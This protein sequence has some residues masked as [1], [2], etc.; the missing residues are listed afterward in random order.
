MPTASDDKESLMY[1][2]TLMGTVGKIM[3]NLC[4][5]SEVW[6]TPF[7]WSVYWC[8]GT[9]VCVQAQPLLQRCLELHE[10]HDDPDSS[11]TGQA[12]F[13]LA[14][15]YA[16]DER[17]RWERERPT[18]TTVLPLSS[19]PFCHFEC[20]VFFPQCGRELL[21]TEPGSVW[22][23]LRR[24]IRT[25]SQGKQSVLTMFARESVSFQRSDQCTSCLCG[26]CTKTAGAFMCAF[27]NSCKPV[28]RLLP[29]SRYIPAHVCVV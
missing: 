7:H 27:L 14:N 2:A 11:S 3:R 23:F 8:R 5:C 13:E 16:Q 28:V 1:V 15:L 24:R 12:M 25:S 21:Q 4:L 17:Y 9:C 18:R 29:S 26:S 19:T 6:A 20:I 22:G 10:S